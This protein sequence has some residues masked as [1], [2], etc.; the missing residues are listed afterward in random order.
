MHLIHVTA[1]LTS[2]AKSSIARA[3]ISLWMPMI[4]EELLYFAASCEVWWK[5]WWY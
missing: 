5:W 1:T 3:V 4:R 2:R